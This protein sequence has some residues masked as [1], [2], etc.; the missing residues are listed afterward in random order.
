METPQMSETPEPD[1]IQPGSPPGP[2]DQPGDPTE[3]LP[4]GEQSEAAEAPQS[5]SPGPAAPD[6][7]AFAPPGSTA[8]DPDQ[9]YPFADQA[10]AFAGQPWA[11]SPPAELRSVAGPAPVLM[12]FGPP[13]SQQRVTVAF[14]A[15]L[16]I[17][18]LIV[19]V[20]LVAAAEVVAFIGWWAA[21]FTGQLP[22]WAHEFI[23]GVLRWQSRV[24]GYL[25]FLTDKY[26]PFSLD[27]ADYP[28]RLFTKQ[29]RL[30]RLAVFFRAILV[31]PVWIVS[32]IMTIGLILVSIVA[33]L[34]TLVTGRMPARLHEA[35]AAIIRWDAR[36]FGYLLLVTPEYPGG[37]WGDRAARPAEA[38]AAAEPSEPVKT[39]SDPW[40]LVLPE[41]AKTLVTVALVIG[42]LGFAANIAYSSTRL[43]QAGNNAEQQTNAYNTVTTGY[44]HLR[45]VVSSFE[46]KVEACDENLTCVTKLDG[47]VAQAF[48]KFGSQLQG[49]DVPSSD[50]A[51]A[52]ALTLANTGVVDGFSMLSGATSA[53]EYSSLASSVDL[54]GYLNN[55]QRDYNQLSKDLKPAS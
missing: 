32:E 51:E 33:W 55:W 8:A 21:L 36:F 49:A 34:I 30:N 50:S 28:V 27:D 40:R 53:S 7:D 38:V 52:S 41:G 16:A 11:G 22:S 29:T 44:S 37:L 42:F 14:R 13:A 45:V 48:Q 25:F 10:S 24:Y 54:E 19:L 47:Q 18:H 15:I 39:D 3:I 46:A 12:S 26:P 4:A 43:Y 5:S 31:I 6:A 20:A 35:F 1:E 2:P 23:T 9:D 17:P